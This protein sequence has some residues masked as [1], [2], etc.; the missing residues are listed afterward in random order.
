M[1]VLSLALCVGGVYAAA[2]PALS[3]P[4]WGGE[5]DQG[6]GNA[7][8]LRDLLARNRAIA[9]ERNR[10]QPTFYEQSVANPQ[11]PSAVL[12]ACSDS[13]LPDALIAGQ[14]SGEIF[15]VRNIA[16]QVLETETAARAS[17]EYAVAS[18]GAYRIIVMG[19]DGCG[20]IAEGH[21]LAQMD[22]AE[23][24]GYS[25]KRPVLPEAVDRWLQPIRKCESSLH[26]QEYA[27]ASL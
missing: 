10:T 2:F 3:G 21:A 14:A 11:R 23:A 7:T 5:I 8:F 18:L 26:C 12:V 1:K 27:I 22:L 15:S 13:R 4:L 20:G 9:E 24:A 16:N 17:I 25:V 6:N 19:H